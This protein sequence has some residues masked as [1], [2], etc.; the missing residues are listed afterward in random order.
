MS[1]GAV[2]HGCHAMGCDTGVPREKLMCWNHWRQVD[3]VLQRRV[4]VSYRRGQCQD[5]SLVSAA[6]L[7][8]AAEA[9]VCVAR[10][11]RRWVGP[12]PLDIGLRDYLLLCGSSDQ[13]QFAERTGRPAPAEQLGPVNPCGCLTVWVVTPYGR[14]TR[15]LICRG[16]GGP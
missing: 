3:P 13:R 4:W 7:R 9:V 12:A 16:H 5:L 8:A 10:K 2:G 14:E 15:S 11:E 6:Y 1:R